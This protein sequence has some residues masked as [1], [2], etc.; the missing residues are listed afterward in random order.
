MLATRTFLVSCVLFLN[1][2]LPGEA[3]SACQ[4]A[5]DAIKLAHHELQQDVQTAVATLSRECK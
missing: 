2:I 3:H 1:Q 5:Q 4:A